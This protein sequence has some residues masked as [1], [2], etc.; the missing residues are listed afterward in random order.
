MA[1][2]IIHAAPYSSPNSRKNVRSKWN[3]QNLRVFQDIPG[4]PNSTIM[5]ELDLINANN[6]K[7]KKYTMKFSFADGTSMTANAINRI[8]R[9][10]NEAYDRQRSSSYGFPE[11]TETEKQQ[12]VARINT[13][14]NQFAGFSH[15]D[16]EDVDI[17]DCTE[18]EHLEHAYSAANSFV[19]NPYVNGPNSK[20]LRMSFDKSGSSLHDNKNGL[21]AALHFELTG[22]YGTNPNGTNAFGVFVDYDPRY[23]ND[24][25]HYERKIREQL[26]NSSLRNGSTNEWTVSPLEIT[27]AAQFTVDAFKRYRISKAHSQ[28]PGYYSP[29]LRHSDYLSVKMS[30]I[31]D[32]YLEHAANP[33]PYRPDVKLDGNQLVITFTDV[34]NNRTA[35][36]SVNL[37]GAKNYKDIEDRLNNLLQAAYADGK[38]WANISKNAF[39]S[40]MRQARSLN[41]FNDKTVSNRYRRNKSS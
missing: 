24:V 7:D 17:I 36:L 21:S 16:S 19:G 3:V 2:Y 31:D 37:V 12:I 4:N 6:P 32:N 30:D 41:I 5:A 26:N 10:F 22:G 9:F 40:I 14:Y 15:S 29:N 8:R 18:D 25:K 1:Q 27:K 33:Y 11:L 38:D 13:A 39:D 34:V 23:Y 28:H 35:T 20:I